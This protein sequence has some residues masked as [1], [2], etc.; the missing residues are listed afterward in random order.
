MS[1]LVNGSPTNEFRMEKG[2]RQGDPIAPFLFILA[3][4]GLKIAMDE[5][6]DKGLFRGVSL[7]NNGPTLSIL[8]YADD[9]IF[10]GEWSNANTSNLVRILRCFQ[11][12]SGLKVN[13]LKSIVMGIGVNSDEISATARRMNCRD[14][15][16]P[17]TYLGMP[18]GAKMSKVESWFLSLRNFKQSFRAGRPKIS[19]LGA[20]LSCAN[21][22]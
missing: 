6:L 16:I 4:E 15:T 2:V 18:M 12:A 3:A 7:P 9:V 5:A 21:R 19:L 13:F 10:L 20:G 1:I 8:Q 22:S 11:L 14:G 17:F